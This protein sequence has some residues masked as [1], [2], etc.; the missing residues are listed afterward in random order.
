MSY[1]HSEGADQH[2]RTSWRS[3]KLSTGTALFYIF[4]F[5]ESVKMDGYVPDTISQP[6]VVLF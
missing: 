2:L 5:R 4:Y 6:N 3:A 1:R